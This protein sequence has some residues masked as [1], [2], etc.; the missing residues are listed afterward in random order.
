M[1]DA[2]FEDLH[3][4][5][6]Q[7]RDA[8]CSN[9]EPTKMHGPISLWFQIRPLQLLLKKRSEVRPHPLCGHHAFPHGFL[10]RSDARSP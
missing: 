4:V 3:A 10:M 6:M 1:F 8:A 2:N 5:C 7:P 9:R